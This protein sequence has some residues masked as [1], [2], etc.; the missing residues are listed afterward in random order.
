MGRI[1]DITSRIILG[2]AELV[3]EFDDP[4][5]AAAAKANLDVFLTWCLTAPA[6]AN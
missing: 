6:D 5:T 3:G 4:G 1:G 2:P